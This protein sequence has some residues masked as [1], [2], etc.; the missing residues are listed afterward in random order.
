[1]LLFYTCSIICEN[2]YEIIVETPTKL[3][4]KKA[5]PIFQM[6][7]SG[8]GM[9]ESL[10]I[11]QAVDADPAFGPTGFFKPFST[12]VD[13]KEWQSRVKDSNSACQRPRYMMVPLPEFNQLDAREA[14]VRNHPLPSFEK[15]TWKENLTS[16]QRWSEYVK[17][18]EQSLTMIDG[19][20]E[21]LKDLDKLIYSENHCSEGGLG[22]DDIDL[23]SRLRSMTLTKGLVWPEKL[24]KYMNNLA[25]Q[26]DMP[27]YF[28]MQV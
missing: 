13:L 22:L 17:S 18:Y 16:Q 14:F 12:R 27:L 10:D 5:V 20:N 4:G 19:L 7:P 25:Q 23:W 3:I 15:A 2:K 28:T 6:G 11:I 21:A 8:K 1:M 26:G 9:P 24:G